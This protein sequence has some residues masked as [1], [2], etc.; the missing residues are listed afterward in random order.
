MD[1]KEAVEILKHNSIKIQ[2]LSQFADKEYCSQ[3]LQTLIDYCSEPKVE[4]EEEKVK[5]ILCSEHFRTDMS[6]LDCMC[7]KGEGIEEILEDMYKKW[8]SHFKL[9]VPS[10]CPHCKKDI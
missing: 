5:M 7:V 8:F 4:L 1:I 3:A 10:E 2:I 9:S 6:F